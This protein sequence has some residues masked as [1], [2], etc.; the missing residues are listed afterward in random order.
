MKT[1]FHAILL[2][3]CLS[4]L[5]PGPRAEAIDISLQYVWPAGIAPVGMP[6]NPNSV[7]APFDP[8]TPFAVPPVGLTG[9]MGYARDYYEDIFEDFHQLH[10]NYWYEDLGDNFLGFNN[11]VDTDIPGDPARRV[12]EANIRIDTQ[13]GSGGALRNWFIDFTPGDDSEFNMQ[14]TLW[15]DLNPSQRS[16]WYNDFGNDIPDT[17]EVGYRG[18]AVAAGP[19]EGAI[20]MLSVVLHEVGHSLG[21]PDLNPSAQ[22]DGDYD[23]NPSFVFGQS[24]AAESLAG[25]NWH[26]SNPLTLMDDSVGSG[27]RER[28]SHTDL[29]AMASGNDYFLLDVPRR[30][31]Y[32]GSF[33]QT[34]G[35]WSGHRRPGSL[36]ETYV[37]DGHDTTLTAPTFAASLFVQEEA[38][39][40]TGPHTLT[41]GISA[42][43]IWQNY[44]RR[45]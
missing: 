5:L 32:G 9:L 27:R 22:N 7:I 19:A 29:Y 45:R 1:L 26:L 35:N 11:I 36:D 40:T 8:T 10:I 17:F 3:T 12:I 44:D 25:D 6:T 42:Y 31:Y 14:Q 16:D 24:L 43:N 18:D 28:P 39:V 33:W 2:S 4:F 37:R 20:D 15:R 23:F 34:E 41:V 38:S 13:V 21:V 30:E